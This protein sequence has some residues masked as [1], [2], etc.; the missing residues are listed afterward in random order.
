MLLL[1]LVVDFAVAV[2]AVVVV[3]IVVVVDV[4]VSAVQ[5]IFMTQ[6]STKYFQSDASKLLS[7]IIE[8]ED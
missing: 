3:A 2:A 6:I 7:L 8:R 1:L 5:N 4:V